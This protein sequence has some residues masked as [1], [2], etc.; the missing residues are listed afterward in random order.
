MTNPKSGEGFGF[1]L[2]VSWTCVVWAEYRLS[3]MLF[4]TMG[5]P[6]HWSP[7]VSTTGRRP[8]LQVARWRTANGERN[9]SNVRTEE[10]DEM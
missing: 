4:G 7:H 1:V 8:G 6:L 5:W 2:F 10:R 3:F 9:S